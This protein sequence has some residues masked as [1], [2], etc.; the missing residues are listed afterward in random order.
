MNAT[1]EQEPY[2]LSSP[3]EW[4]KAMQDHLRQNAMS[5]YA[6]IRECEDRKVCS[7]H[8][9]E[10]LLADQGT[11]TGERTPSLRTAI[12]MARLAGLEITMTPVRKPMGAQS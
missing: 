4:K 11:S 3:L 7:V 6:F 10:C 2:A 1:T 5:R 8:T 9:G 12:A